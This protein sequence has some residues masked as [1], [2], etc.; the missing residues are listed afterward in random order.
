MSVEDVVRERPLG[1]NCGAPRVPRGA[2]NGVSV[3]A[4][5][6]R[7]AAPSALCAPSGG[8]ERSERGGRYPTNRPSRTAVSPFFGRRV[9][10]I[11][12]QSS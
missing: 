9:G 12:T 4:V 10:M 1:H 7:R 3:G 8:S 6:A 5:S 11:S 2:A